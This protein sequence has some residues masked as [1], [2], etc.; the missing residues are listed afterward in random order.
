MQFMFFLYVLT[1]LLWIW[2]CIL[3]CDPIVLDTNTFKTKVPYKIL[4]SIKLR[5][6][7]I[8][9]TIKLLRSAVIVT[10]SIIYISPVQLFP[11]AIRNK[12]TQNSLSRLLH[13]KSVIRKVKPLQGV[14]HGQKR[15]VRKS[16]AQVRDHI[17]SCCDLG[18]F[19]HFVEAERRFTHYNVRGRKSAEQLLVQLIELL[20]VGLRGIVGSANNNYEVLGRQ[21]LKLVY[22]FSGLLDNL[23]Q[24]PPRTAHGSDI[25]C[26]FKRCV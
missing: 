16:T 4:L 23:V 21:F 25:K 11:D 3:L 13:V 6:I 26:P 1:V 10:T 24:R 20:L 22:P 2:R 5:V 14:Y 17:V 12:S 7:S 19:L 15:C 18:V 8:I 9:K